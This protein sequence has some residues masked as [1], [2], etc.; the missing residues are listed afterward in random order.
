MEE[1]ANAI[2]EAK[3]KTTDIS[4]ILK[5]SSAMHQ[6]YSDFNSLFLETWKKLFASYKDAKVNY[7]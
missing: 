2:V 6:R 5:L 7:N 4:F 1:V 3:I